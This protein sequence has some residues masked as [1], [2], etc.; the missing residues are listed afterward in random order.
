MK[1]WFDK[2]G[3][4]FEDNYP[5]YRWDEVGGDD[6]V[7]FAAGL[8][9]H[10]MQ[11]DERDFLDGGV[12]AVEE[13]IVVPVTIPGTDKWVIFRGNP[14]FLTGMLD[15]VLE[16]SS[17][18]WIVDHKTFSDRTLADRPDIGIEVDE[19][20]TSYPYLWWR[21]TGEVPRMSM[22]NVL[23]KVLP[24]PPRRLQRGGLSVAKDQN[25]TAALFRDAIR[26]ARLNLNDY[27]DYILYLERRGDDRFFKRWASPR[28]MSE[29][30]AYERKVHARVHQILQ[31]IEAP[32]VHAY[33]AGSSYRCGHCPFIAPCKATDDGGDAQALLDSYER[34][35]PW[36]VQVD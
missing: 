8:V 15:L 9:N 21:R 33:G 10:Y 19:Q 22:Y 20:L 23:V 31:L 7:A 12:V 16:R 1:V 13:R 26:E 36:Q 14:V 18:L 34:K 4:A 25:T 6:L 28:N 27:L 30:L 29:L 5:L 24:E 3:A 11:Y 17:G 2:Q 35:D 32:Q